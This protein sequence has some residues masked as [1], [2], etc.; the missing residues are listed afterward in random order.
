MMTRPGS[1]HRLH[2]VGDR[3]PTGPDVVKN[4]GNH[5]PSLLSVPSNP[6]QHKTETERRLMCP[7][8]SCAWLCPRS[9]HKA[10]PRRVGRDALAALRQAFASRRRRF[11]AH[12]KN[13][14]PQRRGTEGRVP[15]QNVASRTGSRGGPRPPRPRRR[16]RGTAIAS[17]RVPPNG[18]SRHVG[19]T[20]TSTVC[21]AVTANGSSSR[22]SSSIASSI[23]IDSSD[24]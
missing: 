24:K 9:S 18:V 15:D 8:V 1:A 5:R 17:D 10:P 11:R 19:V 22:L 2:R 7:V 13:E 21:H 4:I 23:A 3:I 14:R 12:E 6:S 20:S 16:Q